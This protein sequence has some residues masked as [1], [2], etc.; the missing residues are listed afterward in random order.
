MKFLKKIFS[1]LSLTFSFLLLI[2]IFFK[3]EIYWSGSKKDYYFYYY[4]FAIILIIFS[5]ISFILSEKIKEY[6]IIITITVTGCFYTFELLLIYEVLNQKNLNL[7][8]KTL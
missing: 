3:S 1:T 6:L 8:K 4:I 5:L 2:Y 7:K